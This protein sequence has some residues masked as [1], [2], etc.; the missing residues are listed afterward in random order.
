M[1][2]SNL[3]PLLPAL[4]VTLTIM[5]CGNARHEFRS[6]SISTMERSRRRRSI[7]K[8]SNIGAQV[9]FKNQGILLRI[10][11][12]R[13][14]PVACKFQERL[15]TFFMQ[16]YCSG[17]V[18]RYALQISWA[19]EAKLTVNFLKFS[20]KLGSHNLLYSTAWEDNYGVSPSQPP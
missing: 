16:T 9:L 1:I 12:V 15:L 8:S 2:S 19:V 11:K 6:S 14:V 10:I 3:R 5:T 7:T 17:N 13:P 20:M 18:S 4:L